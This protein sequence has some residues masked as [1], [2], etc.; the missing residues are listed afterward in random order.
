MSAI[1]DYHFSQWFTISSS[2]VLYFFKYFDTLDD[3]TEHCVFAV[4]VWS[5]DEANEELGVIR[6]G[7]SVCHRQD[8]SSRVFE[9]HV[10]VHKLGSIDALTSCS[11]S[12]RD[13][14]TLCHEPFDDSMELIPPEMEWLIR[15]AKSFLSSTERTEVF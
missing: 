4:K 14:A 12:N 10:L 7:P 2:Y 5:S 8:S 15:F 1:D 3:F 9:I 13:V 6:V 11:I